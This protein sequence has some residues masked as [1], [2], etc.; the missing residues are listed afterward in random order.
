MSV[1]KVPVEKN[2]LTMNMDGSPNRLAIHAMIDAYMEG[3]D[4]K[5]QWQTLSKRKIVFQQDNNFTFFED[6]EEDV[7]ALIN[8]FY[9]KGYIKTNDLLFM[10]KKM[11]PGMKMYHISKWIKANI[12]EI[13]A[14]KRGRG[15]GLKL[16]G[17]V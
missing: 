16:I 7:R 9:N 4:F 17:R 14:S 13:F 15:Y 1:V 6:K 2:D 5:K 3:A 8:S 11:V 10:I 12:G